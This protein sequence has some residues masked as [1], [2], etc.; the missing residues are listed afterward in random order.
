MEENWKATD[1]TAEYTTTNSGKT[2]TGH[3]LSFTKQD[4]YAFATVSL[5]HGEKVTVKGLP[6]DAQVSITETNSDGYS[7]GWQ[8]NGEDQYG[9][10][11]TCRIKADNDSIASVT[12]T[13][14]TGYELPDTGGTGTIPHTMGGLLLTTIA[15]LILMY[16]YKKRRR[17][18]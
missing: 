2:H 12:C 6:H 14:T 9:K 5:Y 10:T 17:E 18:A 11:V 15:G 13:N 3:T 7:V 16:R 1:Y 8:V 4:G